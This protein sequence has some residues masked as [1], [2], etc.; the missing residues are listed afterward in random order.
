[1]L[2]HP[3]ATDAREQE[4][5]A[6]DGIDKSQ[7][8]AALCFSGELGRER[9]LHSVGESREKAE[10]KKAQTQR[11]RIVR[12]CEK[13]VAAHQQEVSRYDDVL[14]AKSVAHLPRRQRKPG[15]RKV[16]QRIEQGD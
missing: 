16:V 2:P 12:E 8:A 14:C 6:C 11:K 5:N 4:P 3:A 1:M 9:T 7:S 13:D 15:V 10:H